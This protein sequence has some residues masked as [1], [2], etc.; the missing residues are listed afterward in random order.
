M[1]VTLACATVMAS[2]MGAAPALALRAAAPVHAGAPKLGKTPAVKGVSAVGSHF[3]KAADQSAPAY[4]PTKVAFPQPAT[5]T[6]AVVQG[7]PTLSAA[8]TGPSV[9]VSLKAAPPKGASYAG[10]AAAEVSVKDRTAAAKAG[11]AGVLFTLT[12]TKAGQGAAQVSLDY[13]A[14][15]QANGGDFGSRLQLVQLPACALTTPELASCRTRTPLSSTNNPTRKTVSA[16][17]QLA[18]SIPSVKG[19]SLLQNQQSAVAAVPMV[20]AATAGS[21]ADGGGPSGTYSATT[22]SASGSWATGGSTGSFTYG[23]P[24]AVPPAP[25]ALAPKLSLDYDSG[26]VDGQTSASQSQSSW[27][28]DGWSM[29]QSY[30][31]RTY[32]PC[33]DSP[34][35]SASPSATYDECYGGEVLTISLN[36]AST[37][38]VYD[39]AK[40]VYKAADDSGAVVTHVTNSSNGSGTYNTD[41]WTV[42]DRTGT[43]FS[44]GRNELPGWGSGKATTNS[45]DSVPVYSAHAGDPCYNSSGFSSSVCTM[46][47]RWNLDYVKDVRGN[48]MSYYYDQDTNYYGENKGASNVSYI[49]DSH[50]NHIDYGFTD[51]NAYGTAPD[52]VAFTP[53]NRCNTTGCGPLT[54]ATSSSWPDVPFDMVCASGAT[55]TAQS[56]S[57]FSTV[58]LASI[59]TQQYDPASTSYKPVDTWALSESM[60]TNGDG[61]ATLW[62]DS[63]TRTGNDLKGGGNTTAL[64]LPPITFGKLDLQNRVDS[65]TDGLPPL[66]RFRVSSITTETGS[67]IGV[68]YTQ[69]TP[70]TAPVTINPAANTSSCYPVYWTPSGYTS[71]ILDWFNKYVVQKVTQTDPTGGA[72]VKATSYDYFNAAWHYDDN[73]VVQ[74]KY[75]TYGQS[76]GYGDVRTYTGDGVND[77]Q[78]ESESVYYQGMSNDN[79]SGTRM[80]TDSQGGAHEDLSQL[81]GKP[82]EE[83]TWTGKGGSVDHSDITSYWV[84]A[85]TATRSRTGLP[86]LTA[87]AIEPVESWKRQALT[88]TGATTW[89][90]NETDK[91]YVTDT[92]DPDFGLAAAT[93][94]HTVPVNTAYD[95]CATTAYAQPNTTLNLVGL[96]ASTETDSV[97]CGG[98][99]QGSPSSVP[100]SVN[101][102]VAPTSVTRP[103]QV[104]TAGRIFYDDPTTA[105]T[106][107]QPAAPTFPQTGAPTL[108]DPSVVQTANGASGGALTYVTTSTQVRDSL[109]RPQDVYD[110]K[111]A[112]T[113]TDYASDSAGNP[114]GVTV[115]NPLGQKTTSTVDPTRGSVLTATDANL[116]VTTNQYDTL[117]RTTGVWLASRAPATNPANYVFAYTVSN[118]GVTAVTTSKMNDEAAYQVSTVIYDALLRPRQTQNPTPQSGR[119]V[120]DTFY[121][122][123]GWSTSTYNG[124]WDSATLPNTT[125]VSATSLK[126][127]VPNQDYLTYDGQGR[128]T[129]DQS[130]QNNLVVS[131]TTTVY[132]GDRTTVLPPTGSTPKT[133]VTDPLGRTVELDDYTTPPTL[134]TPADTFAGTYTVSGGTTQPITYGYDN[135]GKQ[136]QV[137]AGGSTWTTTYNLLGQVTDKV[138]PD[139]GHSAMQY[140]AGG[141]LTQAVDSRGKTVSY[142][143]DALDRKTASYDAPSTGQTS[144]NQLAGWA[145]DNSN[146]V[147]GVTNPVGHLTTTTSYSNGAA[148]QTQEKGFNVFGEPLGQTVTIPASTEGSTL[149]TSYTFTHSYTSTT[150]L[151]FRDVYQG[152][153][154][155][156]PEVVTHGYAGN[157]D[158]PNSLGSTYGYAQG[159][160]HDAYGR[161]QQQTI[162]SAT[163][164]GYITDQYDLHTGRLTDQLVTRQLATPTNVDEQAYTYDL[165]GNITKQISTRLGSTSTVETQCYQYDTLDR[166]SQA[167]T[168]SDSCAATPTAAAHSNVGD[169]VSGGAYWTNW[170]FDALGNRTSQVDHSTTGGTDTS[171]SYTYNG[172]GTGQAHT[173]TSTTAT[174]GSPAATS[175]QYDT[176]G[177]TTQRTTPA[178]GTQTL[179]W[180]DADR[181]TGVTGG[182]AG[183]TNYVYGADGTVLLQKDPTATT[184]YLP[185]EQLTLTSTGALSGTRYYTLPGGG[186]AVRTGT[187]GGPTSTYTFEIPDQHGTAGLALDSTCQTPTWRQFTPYGAARGTA[188]TWSDNRT[189]LNAP[190]DTSTGFT[191]LGV[192][193][194]DSTIGRFLSVDPVFE[195]ADARQL[196][197]YN[198]AGSNPVTGSDPTGLMLYDPE[199]GDTGGTTQQLQDAV[200]KTRSNPDYQD[201]APC[202]TCTTSSDDGGGGGGGKTDQSKHKKSGCHGFWGCAG[203]YAEATGSWIDDHRGMLATVVATAG[204]FVPAVGWAACAGLQA[205]AYGVRTQQTIADDGGWDKN[206]SSILLDGVLTAGTLGIS[207]AV[208]VAKYGSALTLTQATGKAA[209]GIVGGVKNLWN[210][211]ETANWQ[212]VDNLPVAKW[213]IKV[214]T[215]AP[216]VLNQVRK[217]E[218]RVP[219]VAS[220]VKTF[221]TTPVGAGLGW[222]ASLP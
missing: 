26:S 133:T 85:A 46:A 53:G 128:V 191:T 106:W 175:Y 125:L 168:A 33:A 1:T 96:A 74:S 145:Y 60:P 32:V 131:T 101:T 91:S 116:V 50:L 197:G 187:L 204:C 81:S 18:A 104:V 40:N 24:L 73:E 88:G 215:I 30:I 114:T 120:T 4:R 214:A 172:N 137:N 7:A 90:I 165:S 109:G 13:S 190:T 151:P 183:P 39:A 3:G 115:T 173:L 5:A 127:Q 132:N 66:Y 100:G 113:H 157:L 19:K 36:G 84:S 135:R 99:T 23:Y 49:R 189:F 58:R 119:M 156:P 201:P 67:A 111:G 149:G 205:L 186:T 45:V 51:G 206:S 98:F 48:A 31:E 199:T 27:V 15:A 222:A 68:Q 207:G 108:G 52:R 185:G 20:L 59:A 34:E 220:S 83:T 217:Y 41:Y 136:N 35:G 79:G 129:V 176:A 155:L 194:Y 61:G 70:C 44:F 38:L 86:D 158:L 171:T 94:T 208:S 179:S 203:H 213:S 200:N 193:Q 87:N 8:A 105:A 154:G 130:E 102:V 209:P 103:D 160:I 17:V 138:D 76:R 93:Y 152:G 153:A 14:F 182:T 92:T 25:S 118:T 211:G 77:R 16:Q 9:P 54:A 180:D 72:P 28:G 11:I 71:Q 122:T 37:S 89:R 57:F 12:P 10:P 55:C 147:P 134:N 146:G 117:G 78:T 64:T 166:L 178:G 142:T 112:K 6:V 75:R 124:W 97:A 184:L 63:I 169:G 164:E 95:Q 144:G 43:A 218:G 80:L 22:L 62:L 47:Y 216:T 56:P 219:Q 170:S 196:G 140:D 150:G 181:L 202:F 163:S 198:Y 188:T 110:A 195:A 210:V 139:A 121:D 126:D 69:P 42:T 221:M 143:Y 174:G 65:T 161:V 162:G 192:R 82:L 212:A 148:Y 141:L 167:W 107:P 177:N 159:V 2:S 21:P 123:H 29:P